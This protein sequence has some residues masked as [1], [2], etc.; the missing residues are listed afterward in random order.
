MRIA[1]GIYHAAVPSRSAL[2]SFAN[3][4]GPRTATIGDRFHADFSPSIDPDGMGSLTPQLGPG[5][6]ARGLAAWN[7]VK[8]DEGYDEMVIET[9]IPF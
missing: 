3:G 2:A 7:A 8:A 9:G 1:R 4:P 6:D 5:N